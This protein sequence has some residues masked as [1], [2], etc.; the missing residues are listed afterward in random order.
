MTLEIDMVRAHIDQLIAKARE[1]EHEAEDLLGEA[2]ARLQQ[3]AVRPVATP[4]FAQLFANL[5]LT[6][7]QLQ[8][9]AAYLRDLA[10]VAKA[11]V[12][13]ALAHERERLSKP[14]QL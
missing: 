4:A 13:A 9:Q 3:E 5:H 14:P 6:A 2:D 10:D 12:Q 11:G 8:S 1:N 7:L